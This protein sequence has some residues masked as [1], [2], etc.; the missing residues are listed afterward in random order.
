MLVC[1]TSSN[2]DCLIHL[3]SVYA[4]RCEFDFFEKIRRKIYCF[5]QA[6]LKIELT[7]CR[8]ENTSVSIVSAHVFSCWMDRLAVTFTVLIPKEK[9]FWLK[10][11]NP[12]IYQGAETANL[13]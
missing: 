7:K 13:V 12:H 2:L 5:V 11:Y 10:N 9:E 8:F 1:I 3:P 6:L 4:R